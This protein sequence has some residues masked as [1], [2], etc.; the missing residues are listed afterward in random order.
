MIACL[1]DIDDG[2]VADDATVSP[3]LSWT[4][5]GTAY[6]LHKLT[7]WRDHLYPQVDG[8]AH[9]QVAIRE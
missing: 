6:A 9:H 7:F 5:A 8:V 3:E 4:V 2:A 1:D